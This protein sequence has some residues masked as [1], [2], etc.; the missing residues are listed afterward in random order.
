[1]ASQF[2]TFIQNHD[3]VGNTPLGKRLHEL[4][5]PGRFR[6]ATALLLLGPA[7]PMLFQGREYRAA[8]AVSL[9]RRSS[10]RL[11]QDGP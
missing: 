3:Q 5:S 7:T 10:R 1:M 6:A 4:T 2:V 9:F 8:R 11:G